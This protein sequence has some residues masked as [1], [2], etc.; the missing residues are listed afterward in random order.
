[1]DVPLLAMPFV[2]DNTFEVKFTKIKEEIIKFNG[3]EIKAD[4]IK[5]DYPEDVF[6]PVKTIGHMMTTQETYWILKSEERLLLKGESNIGTFSK[7]DI[8]TKNSFKLAIIDTL[9]IDWWNKGENLDLRVYLNN[10]SIKKE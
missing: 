5:V 3:E 1:M 4:V 7:G 6:P 9:N 2:G 8:K 10:Y